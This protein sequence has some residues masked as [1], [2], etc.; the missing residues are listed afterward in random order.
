MGLNLKERS[1]GKYQGLLKITKRGPSIV[2]RWLYFAAMRA[3]QSVFVKPW[4]EAKKAKDKDRGKGAL[5]AVARKL[6]LALH[7]VGARANPFEPWRLVSQKEIHRKTGQARH[8][9]LRALR[10]AEA[11]CC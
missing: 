3:A 4:F 5:I 8:N 10:K 9:A 2:R 6:A 11:K 7:S 1:S